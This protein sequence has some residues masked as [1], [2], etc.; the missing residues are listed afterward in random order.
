MKRHICIVL[1]IFFVGCTDTE[2]QPVRCIVYVANES[3]AEVLDAVSKHL[4]AAWGRFRYVTPQEPESITTD[5][6]GV[7][8]RHLDVASS[9]VESACAPL[10]ASFSTAHQ[11][12]ETTVS[13]WTPKYYQSIKA[14]ILVRINNQ[15][16]D[17]GL[18][19]LLLSKR[20]DVWTVIEELPIST[21]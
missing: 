2:K 5:L 19:V 7:I 15:K 21:Y 6:R 9:G 14:S 4:F 20:E 10:M 8:S 11:D 1:G 18:S 16:G 3:D 17:G 12:A 13:T